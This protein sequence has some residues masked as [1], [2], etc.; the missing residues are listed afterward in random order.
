VVVGARDDEQICFDIL[1]KDELTRLRT[2]DPEILRHLTPE[3]AADLGPYDV[4]NPIHRITSALNLPARE[5]ANPTSTTP[6]WVSFRSYIALLCAPA[7]VPSMAAR[8]TS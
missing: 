2:F 3:H 7:T 6:S 1:V 4:R 8:P 5:P